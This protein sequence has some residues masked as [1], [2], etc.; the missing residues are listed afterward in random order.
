MSNP[1]IQPGVGLDTVSIRNALSDMKT[2]I[3]T[4]LGL[5]E[6]YERTRS[7]DDEMKVAL[8]MSGFEIKASNFARDMRESFI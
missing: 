7:I 8:A 1:F 6:K 5:V 2:D 4:V 3:N